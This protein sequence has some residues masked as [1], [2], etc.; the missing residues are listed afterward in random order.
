MFGFPKVFSFQ[1]ILIRADLWV[2]TLSVPPSNPL[3]LVPAPTTE[4]PVV[5][6]PTKAPYETK[7]GL[8]TT[9]YWPNFDLNITQNA[10]KGFDNTT[11]GPFGF[12]KAVHLDKTK[13]Q[14][15]A[16]LFSVICTRY[17]LLVVVFG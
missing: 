4:D 5:V 10:D 15:L 6:L 2:P 7:F 1:D 14:V 16:I 9:Y 11:D 3:S 13:Q 12:G 8:T 17:R